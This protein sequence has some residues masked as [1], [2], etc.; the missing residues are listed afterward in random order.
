MNSESDR[1]RQKVL[2]VEP[3]LLCVGRN[4]LLRRTFLDGRVRVELQH[5]LDVL[6]RVLLNRRSLG[7]RL[8]GFETSLDLV[9]LEDALEIGVG[10]DGA[11]HR[12]A[13][14]VSGGIDSVQG[15]ER[16]CRPDGEATDVTAGSE[17]EQV[18]LVDGQQSDTGDVTE[19]EGDAFVFF[20]DNEG[21]T[22]L[23]SSAVSHFAASGTESSGGLDAFNVGPGVKF[24]KDADGLF[25]LLHAL[26][27]IVYDKGK[28]GD[29]FDRVT[30]SHGEGGDSGGGNGR[31]GSVTTLGY[32]HASVPSAPSLVW[33]EHSSTTAHVSE[34]GSA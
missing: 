1:R 3:L 2:R 7:G 30:L 10:E 32:I 24:A 26:D 17:L 16:A 28:F 33:V 21:T 31:D 22:F 8:A 15:L 5:R 11:R 20:V 25:R 29:G 19:S 18:Q 14:F 9:G 13:L 6:Q 27:G 23:H 34:R 12:E 4:R